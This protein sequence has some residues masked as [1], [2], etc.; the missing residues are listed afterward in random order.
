MRKSITRNERTG[1]PTL[2]DKIKK[3]LDKKPTADHL[4]KKGI[5]AEQLNKIFGCNVPKRIKNRK[6][7]VRQ[8]ATDSRRKS[9]SG[10]NTRNKK[11]PFVTPNTIEMPIPNWFK[12]TGPIDVSI[13]VPLFKSTHVIQEQIKSWDFTNDGLSKEII[14]VDD[15]CPDKSYQIVLKTW[16]E[17]GKNEPVGRI[18]L[19]DKNSGFSY[20][21]N[22]GAKHASGKYVIFLNADCQTTVNWIKP[23][24][25]LL[26]KDPIIGLVGNLQLRK[27]G[28]ID[29]A[30][31]QWSW[32]QKSFPHIGRNI[33]KGKEGIAP[34]R[35]DTNSDLLLP[36]E[37]Q[38][39]T[40]ACMAME[41]EFFY[42]LEG[43]DTKYRVGYWEDADLCMKVHRAERKVYYQPESRV[44]HKV[45]H[46]NAWGHAYKEDNRN[47]FMNR[48]VK[49]G[50]L[51]EYIGTPRKNGP[52]KLSD[53]F[54]GKVVGCVI[55]CNEEEFLEVSV[56]SINPIVDEW[57]FVIGGNEFAYKSG[58]C[59]AKGYPQDSTLKIAN[60]L[61]KKYN[62]IVIEPPGRLWK[63]KS[64]MRSAY[65]KKLNPGDW[66]FML[67]GDE[68]YTQDQLWRVAELMRTNEVLVMQFWLFWNNMHTLGV[69]KWETFPQERVVK[70]K[71]G[72]DY[73][74]GSHLHVLDEKGRLVKNIVPCWHGDEKLFY[75]YSWVRP[76]EK[77][78]QKLTYYK[79]QTGN[80]NDKYVDDVFL[81]WRKSPNS[82][83][84]KTHPMGGGGVAPFNGLH[85]GSVQKLL[86]QG[87]FNFC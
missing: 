51:E 43:F 57:I 11:T 15:A 48:W 33:Y 66:M 56:D 3:A 71:K 83:S 29:S 53:H 86:D 74:N 27:D 12:T 30:G 42:E 59:D 19:N 10:R 49:T 72:Y 77:I 2:Q 54:Q 55:A 85:P 21:C 13:I 73:R 25:D 58:M 50:L 41:K 36:A 31:S 34:M 78:R 16:T 64:E 69:G 17:C 18:L 24:I 67:D 44:I 22:I 32:R 40:G 65:A 4:S 63:D 70:W 7:G 1:R 8:L 62:G 81:L 9:V 47:L 79:H 68:V 26:K 5:S 61:A 76:I 45:G 80:D 60:K 39:V 28:T 37:R 75:H 82:V 46:A 35:P 84:N 14:Y 38:M 6:G 20:T 52:R 23:M 87:R